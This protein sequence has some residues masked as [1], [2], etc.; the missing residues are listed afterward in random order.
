MLLGLI[1]FCLALVVPVGPARTIGAWAILIYGTLF[2]IWNA[3]SIM[4]LLCNLLC[5]LVRRITFSPQISELATAIVEIV[6][7]AQQDQKPVWRVHTSDWI[8][9]STLDVGNLNSLYLGLGVG[10]LFVMLFFWFYGRRVSYAVRGFKYESLQLGSEFVKGEIPSF[11][12]T[13]EKPGLLTKTFVGYAVRV[14][15]ALCIPTHVLSQC[16]GTPLIGGT[17]IVTNWAQSLKLADVSYAILPESVF[18]ELKMRKP[19]IGKIEKSVLGTCAGRSGVSTG[20]LRRISTIGMVSYSGSTL[21]GY[22]GA[23]YASQNTLYGMHTGES[24]AMLN[25]GVSAMFLSVEIKGRWAIGEG[26]KVMPVSW[27]SAGEEEAPVQEKRK[28]RVIGQRGVWTD[29]QLFDYIGA[30]VAVAERGDAWFTEVEEEFGDYT[31]ESADDGVD[32]V[33][34]ELNQKQKKALFKKLVAEQGYLSYVGQSD[35]GVETIVTTDTAMEAIEAE[36]VKCQ[37]A[38]IRISRRVKFLEDRAKLEYDHL[39]LKYGNSVHPVAQQVSR[40]EPVS[41]ERKQEPVRAETPVTEEVKVEKP[42]TE[43]AQVKTEK[44]DRLA[45]DFCAKSFKTEI[46]RIAHKNAVHAFDVKPESALPGDFQTTS[47]MAFL[48]KRRSN[49]PWNAARP[50]REKKVS[51]SEKE[52][53]QFSRL[54]ESQLKM[55]DILMKQQASLDVLV[56]KLCGQSSGSEQN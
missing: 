56:K 55:A 8:P 21:P 53:H 17:R 36:V 51:A 29:K 14:D 15:M 12:A 6:N 1:E 52:D 5:A 22:S 43:E 38:I 2:T 45:C 13:V 49:R 24:G 20:M 39:N 41:V 33:Y 25:C 34:S 54:S 32:E 30:A 48:D 37:E 9:D 44:T 27:F 4:G 18:S 11:Q 19:S 23:A 35:D 3:G 28:D 46:G 50:K 31:K 40:E 26:K 47:K 16:G 7:E 10:V 42:V